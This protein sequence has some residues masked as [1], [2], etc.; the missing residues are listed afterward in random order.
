MIILYIINF[1]VNIMNGLF[2]VLGFIIDPLTD[3][4]TFITNF[5][6][7][8]SLLDILGLV[9]IFLPL[10]TILTLLEFTCALILI[11]TGLSILHVLSLGILFD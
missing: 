4:T 9:A 10:G 11:K 1:L 8:Q 3:L 7:A 6:I 5:Q 2:S